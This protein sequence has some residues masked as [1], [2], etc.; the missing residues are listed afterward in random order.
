MV[1]LEVA[2]PLEATTTIEEEAAV[3][4]EARQPI[5]SGLTIFTDGSRLENE[6]TGYAVTCKKGLTWK[7]HKTHMGWGQEAYDANVPPLRGP[8]KWRPPGAT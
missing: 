8:S 5:R 7:G 3:V 2:T 6:A 1:L 4:N